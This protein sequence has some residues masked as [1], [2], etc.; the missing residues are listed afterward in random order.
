MHT[1]LTIFLAPDANLPVLGLPGDP[2]AVMNLLI[3]VCLVLGVIKIPGLMGRYITQSKP[4]A[5]GTVLRVVLIQQVTQGL[6]RGL[7]VGRGAAGGRR[8]GGAG[9]TAANQPWPVRSGGGGSRAA[10]PSSV[11][12]TPRSGGV[13][14]R[15]V[16]RPTGAGPGRTGIAFP[17]GRPVRPYTRDELAGGVD[18]YTRAMKARAGASSRK[19]P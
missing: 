3:V 19:A 18:L 6:R 15:Q 10:S 13:T 14:P 9:S 11:S 17:T 16:P 1:T 8:A 5:L 2:G 12:H 7:S 4:A